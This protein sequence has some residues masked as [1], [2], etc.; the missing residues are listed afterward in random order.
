MRVLARSISK[1]LHNF[2]HANAHILHLRLIEKGFLLV[3]Y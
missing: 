3:F 1:P 2:K